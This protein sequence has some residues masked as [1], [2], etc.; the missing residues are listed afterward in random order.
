[1]IG[2]HI[3]DAALKKN[4]HH[5]HPRL[6]L[7]AEDFE[8]LHKREN[9]PAIATALKEIR[10]EADAYMDK[11]PFDYC[12]PDGVRMPSGRAMSPVMVCTFCYRY[13]GDVKYAERA[14]LELEHCSH[15]PDFHP[16]HFLDQAGMCFAYAL[17]YDWL[18]DWMNEEQKA[19]VSGALVTLGFPPYEREFHNVPRE[20][21]RWYKD[22]PGDNW[23]MVC[24]S[25]LTLSILAIF[26]DVP[27]DRYDY[28]LTLAFDDTQR[29][30]LTFYSDLDGSYSE[31]PS[32]WSYGTMY[33][34]Y[35]SAG[36]IS[37]CG[38]DFEVCDWKGLAMSPYSLL[39][40]ASNDHTSFNFGDASAANVSN[41]VFYW[42]ASRFNDGYIYKVVNDFYADNSYG[43]GFQILIHNKPVPESDRPLP[44][45]YGAVGC[46]NASFRTDWSE[47]GLFAAIHFGRNNAYHG[48]LDMGH[49]IINDGAV[50]FFHDFGLDNY[51][52][53]PYSGCYRCRAEGHNCLVI[54]P[55]LEDDQLRNS[56]AVV[57]AFADHGTTA[58]A[59]GNMSEAFPGHSVLRGLKLDR[60]GKTV[61]I[62]DEITAAPT[63]EIRWYA[64][65][66]GTVTL[67]AD[68]RAA[69]VSLRE[70]TMRVK[71]V[72]DGT[73]EVLPCKP[74]PRSPVLGPALTRSGVLTPQE[75]NDG[76]CKL[77]VVLT[78]KE[79][80]TICAEF[81]QGGRVTDTAAFV[82]LKDW[83]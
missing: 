11:P 18:Y 30:V 72:G 27:S 67:D 14:Y 44:I 50:R 37:A 52:L 10:A 47:D 1:M 45:S 56:G 58:F 83:N 49:F 36:L 6:F 12:V 34:A 73:F 5:D 76:Y 25:A 82:P 61:T 2:Q 35:Y 64:Q 7:R 21:Y 9:E 69:T 57:D 51:N 46:D 60:A 4:P 75:P 48:H 55:G 80:Y 78:G 40:L 24:N 16:R 79:K 41:F 66:A 70:K 65:T 68:G 26:D 13:F 63:D 31:G 38:E 77:A 20:G 71:L 29:A 8:A 62:Q 74:D 81:A 22:I 17:G 15:F 33:L 39:S 53:K 32:Y 59:V 54:N 42:A 3:L 23:K 28:L 19:V 43:D